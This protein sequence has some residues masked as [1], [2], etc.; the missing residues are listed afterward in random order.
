VTAEVFEVPQVEVPQ[1]KRCISTFLGSTEADR[2]PEPKRRGSPRYCEEDWLVGRPM[3]E[4]IA[5]A[6][7]R[8]ATVPPDL[9]VAR[10]PAT[11][12]PAGRRW[13]AGCQAFVRLTDCAAGSARCRPCAARTAREYRLG[14]DYG[15]TTAEYKVL[16]LSQGGV[17][18]LCGKR[19]V[20]RPLAVD[21]DHETGE[22][23][24]LLCPDPDWGCNLKIVARA[25]SSPGGGL[26]FALRLVQYYRNPPARAVLAGLRG[27]ET[28]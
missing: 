13:C 14:R 19:S 25:D 28:S 9:H 4:Q 1:Q 27:E 23:R 24:G 7:E 15:I 5:A 22:V 10:V 20:S 21:H 8:R 6:D 16:W 12:W 11:A 26:G 3:Q 2:C 17:C 18:Y